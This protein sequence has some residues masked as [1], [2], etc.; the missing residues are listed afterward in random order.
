M[1]HIDIAIAP[2]QSNAF[3]DSKSDIKVAECGRY[4]VPLV[5]T[6]VGCYSDTIVNGETGYLISPDAPKSEWVRVLTKMIK[7]PKGTKEM[8][9]N[10][11][12]ITEQ[13]FDL[14]KVAYHRLDILEF[15]LEKVLDSGKL[16]LRI[17]DED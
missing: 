4:K 14:N 6:D 17:R 3:N 1:Q 11:H 2:L 15:A 7:D 16:A 5:A 10:L 9:E 8:G 13:L 12:S